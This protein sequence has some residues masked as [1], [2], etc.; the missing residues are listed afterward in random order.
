MRR[1]AV[2]ACGLV[3]GALCLLIG[4]GGLGGAT[5]ELAAGSPT[6]GAASPAPTA[7]PAPRP[8]PRPTPAPTRAPSPPPGLALRVS[9]NQLLDAR[10]N[11]I[12][13]LGVDRSGTEYACIQGWGIFDGP[14]DAASVQTIAS[15]HTNAVRVPL[16]E[17]CWLDIN[18]APAAYSGATYQQAIANYV[19]LLNQDGLV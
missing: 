14:S 2:V 3:A 16:N 6:L 15:W 7:T 8:T 17:D 12:R 9:G 4:P 11:R 19:N 13:L 18:G 5:S 1:L 10:G